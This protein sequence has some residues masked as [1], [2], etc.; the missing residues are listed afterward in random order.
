V[1]CAQRG[2][3]LLNLR[4]FVKTFTGEMNEVFHAFEFADEKKRPFFGQDNESPL[5]T[6]SGAPIPRLLHKVIH[7][8]CEQEISLVSTEGCHVLVSESF[9]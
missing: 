7:S 9:N 2:I 4:E 1:F 8:F 3:S 5:R 6:R